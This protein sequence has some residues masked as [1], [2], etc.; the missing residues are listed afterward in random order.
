MQGTTAHV[1][2]SLMIRPVMQ[3]QEAPQW[4]LWL[5]GC[6]YWGCGPFSPFGHSNNC[7]TPFKCYQRPPRGSLQAIFGAETVVLVFKMLVLNGNRLRWLKL[8]NVNLKGEFNMLKQVL[9]S[10][11]VKFTALVRP[12][13][14]RLLSITWIGSVSY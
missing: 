7:L 11:K 10:V 13:C 9:N 1:I 2:Y 4:S 5:N 8:F 14:L 3:G 12:S 6:Q